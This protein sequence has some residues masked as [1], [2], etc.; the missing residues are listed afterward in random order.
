[1]FLCENAKPV[2]G[3]TFK[4]KMINKS[5]CKK[6]CGKK[7][8][9]AAAVILIAVFSGLFVRE[10]GARLAI[11]YFTQKYKGDINTH[12]V[13]VTKV[14]IL[15]LTSKAWPVSAEYDGVNF[16]IDI[17]NNNDNFAEKYTAAQYIKRILSEYRGGNI[18][19]ISVPFIHTMGITN[20]LAL[21]NLF[22][23][24]VSFDQTINSKKS[25]ING[26]EE[27]LSA[28]YRS[29]LS[30]CDTFEAF[31]TI[32]GKTMYIRVSPYGSTFSS[33]DIADK[34]SEFP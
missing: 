22:F 29:G 6:A 31:A 7:N 30:K 16:Q 33:K 26:T 17:L 27:V 3:F 10:I 12:D 15:Q 23:L 32:D 4:I 8:V 18:H 2:R 21:D 19:A 5:A 9:I 24:E 34:I 14:G 11:D 1:M 13:S 25:F 28:L 20:P